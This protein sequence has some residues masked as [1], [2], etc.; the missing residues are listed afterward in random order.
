MYEIRLGLS[1]SFTYSALTQTCS[2]R[3]RGGIVVMRQRVRSDQI[4]IDRLSLMTLDDRRHHILAAH[5][6]DKPR[7]I[8]RGTAARLFAHQPPNTTLATSVGGTGRVNS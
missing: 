6:Q 5:F 4:W 7:Q 1:S 8:F 3:F 2:G